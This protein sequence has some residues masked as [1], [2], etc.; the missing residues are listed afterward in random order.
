MHKIDEAIQEFQTH[1][2]ERNSYWDPQ[3]KLTPLFFS[4]ELAGEIGEACNV[5]K[6]LE[7]ERLGL[8]GSRE[9]IEHL[10]EELEDSIICAILL[11]NSYGIKLAPTEK[12]NATSR[13]LGLPEIK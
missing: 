11:A 10:K 5:V 3:N 7:R 12:Y 1:N 4:T 13:K 8:R 6:K 9:T 2:A